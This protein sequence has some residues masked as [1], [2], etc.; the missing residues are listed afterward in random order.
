MNGFSFTV[1]AGPV[2]DF[3]VRKLEWERDFILDHASYLEEHGKHILVATGVWDL[4]QRTLIVSH[5]E[6]GFMYED[7]SPAERECLGTLLHDGWSGTGEE[8]RTAARLLAGG[9]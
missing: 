7:L 3:R 5:E 8:A 9:R 1:G 2:D 6:Y 4:D